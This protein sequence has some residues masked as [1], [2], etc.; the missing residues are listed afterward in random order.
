MNDLAVASEIDLSEV[1]RGRE[2]LV[3]GVTGFL[4]KVALTMLLDRYPG[5]GRIHVLVRPRA[6]G[7]AEDR[8]F[9]RVIDTEP[10]RPLRE[11]HGDRFEEF[12]REKCRP[13]AGDVSEPL[14]GIPEAEIEALRGRLGCVINCAGLVT[15]NPSLELAV[16]VNTDGAGNAAEVCRRTDATLVHVS[17]CFVAGTRRGPVFEDEPV[18]G[19]F[20]KK[21]AD[22]NDEGLR[23]AGFSLQQELRDVEKLVA[24]LR[25]EADDH[26]LAAHFR[27]AAVRRLES[28]GRSP[29]DEKALRLAAGRERKLWLSQKLVEAGM[30]R[31]QSWGWPNT[32]TYTKA[33]GEQA[34]ATSGCK[35]AIVRPA[36]VESAIRFPFPG[37]NEGFTTSA[38]LIFMALKGH[39]AYPAGHKLILDLIPVDLVAAGIL[40]IAGA[41]CIGRAQRVYQLAS[42]DVNPLYVRRSVEL[43]ALSKRQSQ[44]AKAERTRSLRDWIDAWL[45]PYT[46]SGETYLRTSTPMFRKL[47]KAGRELIADRGASWGAP[48]TTALLARADQALETAYKKLAPVEMTWELFLPFVAGERF[49]FQCAHTRALWRQLSPR[50]REKLP[51]DPERIDWRRYWLD[52]HMKGLEEWVFPGLEEESSKD[53]RELLQPKDL[54]QLLNASVHRY[55]KRI[56]LRFFA[57]GENARELERTR[58]DR[59]T[60]EELGKFSDRAAHSLAALGVQP[61]ERVLLLSENRPEWAMAYFGILKAGAT[62]AP[63]DS[64]LSLA[65]IENCAVA[66]KAKVLV[67]SPRALERLGEVPQGLR[68]VGL[69]ELLRGAPPSR[70]L[71]VAAAADEVASILFTSGTTGKPKGVLLTHRNFASLASKIGTLFDLHVGEGL[72]SVLPLHHTFE[73]S[74]GLLVPLLVGAEITYLDELTADRLSEALESGR[75][76]A[77]IGVPALWQLLHRRITQELAARPRVVEGMVQ[78]AMALH[79]ELRNRTPF[80]VGKLLFWP[81]HRKFGGNLRLLVSGGAALPEEVHKAFHELGLDLTEGYGLTEAA[82]VLSVT[83]PRNERRSG[84]VGPP[85]PGIEIRIDDPDAEGVGEV[86]AKGPNVMAGYLD[87]PASTAKVLEKGW[88]R[89]GDLGKLDEE[90][91]LVLVGR[92]KDLILDASGKNVYPD[93]L[94]ELYGKSPLLEE[95][96]VVGL[97]D[98]RGHDRIACLAVA[99][100]PEAGETREDL[101]GR[102]RDHF[103][104]VSADLPLWKRVKI[105]HFWEGELPKTATRKVKRPQVVEELLRMERAARSGARVAQAAAKGE[106]AWLFELLA[107]LVRKPRESVGPKTRLVADLGFDSLLVA[108]LSVALEKAGVVPPDEGRLASMETASDLARALDVGMGVALARRPSPPAATLDQE[109]DIAQQADGEKE[110]QVPESVAAAGRAAIGFFQRA[111]Y[112]G[113]FDIEVSGKS[114]VPSGAPFLVAANHSSHLDVGLVKSA[115]GDEGHKLA[116]LAA[117]DYFFDNPWKRAWFGN[118]T[119]LVPIERRGSLKESLQT[120]VRTLEYGYHLLLF[121]EGTRSRDGVLQEFKPAIAYLALAAG[122]DILPVYLEGTHEA[123]PKGAFL[124]DPRKRKK[125]RVRMGP[126]LRIAE[127]RELTQGLSRSSAY[128]EIT[129][130]VRL[131]I[132]ALR[133]GAP[134][135]R[136][137]RAPH[138]LEAGAAEA[139][140]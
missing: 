22:D 105:L 26:A 68:A 94:E 102:I 106:D 36:I 29:D 14:L 30:A 71:R 132:E 129:R 91:H 37:W 56:A 135:P 126:P 97:R 57:G 74:C 28:E 125:L 53:L 121:P 59:V 113:L 104:Q 96:S 42:G 127:L 48:I 61:G 69:P 95:L 110:I 34:I 92:K 12:L 38:P 86:I 99:R 35:Y 107:D 100:D 83:M 66:A 7:S 6:G 123:M 90:G 55:G 24:R 19:S 136:I 11:R 32:Y 13:M 77:L 21:H 138:L 63:L 93:E 70:P 72:L 73:F 120:A 116:S 128:R 8:F 78:G 87:D 67:A 31:A 111:L 65:E 47:A 85:L 10:F 43:S 130:H 115:L 51:W 98:E 45:E 139:A 76:H 49:V 122:V 114:H 60:Y 9:G 41:A 119:N 3:T 5:I 64:Q 27:A 40:G 103:A 112:G 1:F 58:D 109:S 46:V 44:R 15:F 140:K 117:R 52:V 62:A 18:L 133:D 20:P 80:N 50:D 84:N 4:G 88:L 82:P 101:R 23:G 39:R 108:E 25:E 79:G 118:F 17:T 89:T 81:I 134:P 75:I 33:L 137:A 131:A 54:L 124:P 16:A 2:I